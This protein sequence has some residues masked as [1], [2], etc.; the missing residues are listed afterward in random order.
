MFLRRNEFP[1]V[2]EGVIAL[3]RGD[4]GGVRLTAVHLAERFEATCHVDVVVDED[5]A[6]SDPASE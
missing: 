6:S 1:R 3:A 4:R 2:G 5:N